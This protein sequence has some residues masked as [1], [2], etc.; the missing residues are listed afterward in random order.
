MQ[1]KNRSAALLMT[2]SFSL[3][4]LAALGMKKDSPKNP[5]M[6]DHITVPAGSHN[7]NKHPHHGA[8]PKR[9][10]KHFDKAQAISD[11]NKLQAGER[12]KARVGIDSTKTIKRGDPE[13]Q[14]HAL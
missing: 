5:A 1:S 9:E 7:K 13:K 14:R 6:H 4:P 10:A 12:K 3:L 8:E 11:H 2:A